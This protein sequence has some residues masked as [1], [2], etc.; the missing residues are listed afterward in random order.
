[1]RVDRSFLANTVLAILVTVAT[2]SLWS[3]GERRIDV[4]VALYTLSYF[5]VKA[6]LA[7]RRKGVDWLAI[8]L[9]ATFF[10]CVAYRVWE[11]LS[12]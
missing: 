5:V 3:A 10:A 7:P 12:R 4:Y 8:A 11:V 2:C 6:V 1:L 9:A